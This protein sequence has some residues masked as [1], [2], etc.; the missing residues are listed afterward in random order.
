MTDFR[1]RHFFAP[2]PAS[3]GGLG[4]G[5]FDLPHES[6]QLPQLK[7]ALRSPTSPCEQWEKQGYGGMKS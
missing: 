3:R 6:R 4:R 2:S 7:D 1:V 5:A